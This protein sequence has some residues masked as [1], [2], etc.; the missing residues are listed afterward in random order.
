MDE[1]IQNV[2]E[3]IEPVNKEIGEKAQKYVD[4]LTKPLGSLGQL[5]DLAI[6]LVEMTSNPFPSVFP[7]GVVVFAADHGIA[8]AGVSAYP[9]EVTAQMVMNFL[10]GGAAIN[11]FSRQIQAIT[12]IVDVGVCTDIKHEQLINRKVRYGTANF[13]IKDAMSEE[14][15]NEAICY[16][17]EASQSLIDKGVK[18]LI[19]GELGI[20]NTT[21]SAAILAALTG[22]NIDQ[23]VGIGTGI[24]AEKVQY[25]R[26]VIEKA[27]QLRKPNSN[28]PIDVLAK[29]GGLEIAA[30]VGAMLQAAKHKIPII[31]DGF[32]CT[33]A[34]LIAQ[35]LN[36][37][38]KDYMII[39]HQSMEPGHQVAIRL[40]GKKP[41]LNLQMRLGEGSG[42]ALAYPIVEA[43]CRMINEMATF[44]EAGVSQS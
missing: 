13:L 4:T 11:V 22:I 39:G 30:M 14:E 42:A 31:V 5:E 29:V 36:K 3:A 21:T 7:P 38:V 18:S 8:S 27:L 9:Q 32:I 35:S 44:S 20:G 41:I 43:A 1:M 2:I 28:D 24:N 40:L 34:A 23:L 25:K 19:I 26:D 37:H 17:M 16:G 12:S 33:T 10:Q 15:V 6:Q